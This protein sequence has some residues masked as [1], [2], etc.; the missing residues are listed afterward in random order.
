[1]IIHNWPGLDM[2][3]ALAASIAFAAS[4]IARRIISMRIPQIVDSWRAQPKEDER[5]IWL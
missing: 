4:I 2:L 5:T 1:M 3:I